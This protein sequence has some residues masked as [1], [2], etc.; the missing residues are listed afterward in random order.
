MNG[1]H[2]THVKANYLDLLNNRLFSDFS[3]K[4]KEDIFHC[5][6]CI[7]YS[8][9]EF[10]KAYLNFNPNTDE[11]NL[12]VEIVT[13]IGIKNCL[14]FLYQLG[15]ESFVTDEHCEETYIAADYLQINSLKSVASEKIS[16]NINCYNAFG[17]FIVAC[18]S[19]FH[20]F[21]SCKFIV[22]GIFIFNSLSNHLKSSI[23]CFFYRNFFIVIINVIYFV[24]SDKFANIKR[25][26]SNCKSKGLINC[27]CSTY[28]GFYLTSF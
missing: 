8:G 15:C 25:I 5:H 14:L 13:S 17:K 1:K 23:V 28:K 2:F 6:K 27:F 21:F 19:V 4:I 18:L 3:I 9:S 16:R 12:S 24:S 26:N 10:F 11:L 7:L 22:F 20:I